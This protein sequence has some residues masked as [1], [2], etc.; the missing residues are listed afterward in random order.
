V[1]ELPV[2]YN[3]K[4]YRGDTWVQAF[5]F[6][7]QDAPLDLNGSKVEAWVANPDGVWPLPVTV[8]PDD[9]VVTLGMPEE[10]LD[11]NAYSYDIEVVDADGVVTT[12]VRG[13]LT[14]SQDVTNAV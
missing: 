12:W 5:R 10:E 3:L 13:R 6:I 9:G 11:A 2:T 7:W 4:A 8:T 14:V 1:A